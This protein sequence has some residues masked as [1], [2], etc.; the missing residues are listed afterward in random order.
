M[1]YDWEL[2]DWLLDSGE[3]VTRKLIAQG[4]ASLSPVERFLR[5]VWLL[6]IQVRNGGVSQY[7]C[8]YGLMSIPGI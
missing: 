4:T 5:E 2:E 3:Q 6:D 7:F 1:A 8:N